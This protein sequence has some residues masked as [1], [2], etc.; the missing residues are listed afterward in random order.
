VPG[1]SL[2]S[3]D[4]EASETQIGDGDGDGDALLLRDHVA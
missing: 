1:G 2:E 4:R 3:L